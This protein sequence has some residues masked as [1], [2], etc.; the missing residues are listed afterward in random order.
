M[1]GR[2]L[3]PRPLPTPGPSMRRMSHAAAPALLALALLPAPAAAQ[4]DSA[5][6]PA[7]SLYAEMRLVSRYIWRGYD[8][9]QKTP[10]LQPYVETG[11]PFGFT[12]NAFATTAFDRHHDLDEVQLGLGYSQA[13]GDWEF[14]VGYLQYLLPGTL[15]EPS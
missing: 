12:A 5:A 7:F 8:D 15:T 13:F 2:P 9:A 6:A 14:G 4:S 10:S 3:R 1:L 11:L